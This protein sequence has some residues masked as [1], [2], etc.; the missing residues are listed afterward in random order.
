[1]ERVLSKRPPV[2]EE[3]DLYLLHGEAGTCPGC[4]RSLVWIENLVEW[5]R[6][7]WI[8]V[9]GPNR[10]GARGEGVD[11]LACDCWVSSGCLAVDVGR[12][13]DRV[14]GKLSPEAVRRAEESFLE[15]KQ[16]RERTG[17]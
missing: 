8:Y 7:S 10:A 14:D 5:Y 3:W 11:R 4:G 17:A 9:M 6:G 12:S 1:M 13:K 2:P 15:L 16:R